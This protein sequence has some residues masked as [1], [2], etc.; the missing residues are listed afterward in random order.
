M[1]PLERRVFTYS[2]IVGSVTT[3]LV[4][5]FDGVG[6][7]GG[8]ERFM[9]DRRAADCQ[10]FRHKPSDRIIHLDIDDRSLEAIG[11]WP[12]PRD[13]VAA[14]LEEIGRAGPKVVGTDIVYSEPADPRVERRGNTTVDIDEDRAMADALGR[15]GNV[16]I[17]VSLKLAPTRSVTAIETALRGELTANL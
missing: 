3:L 8:L 15:M 5:V 10:F 7:L 14:I 2:A 1:T 17:P 13:R 9:Y 16:V 12:W 4:L 6:W 11:R